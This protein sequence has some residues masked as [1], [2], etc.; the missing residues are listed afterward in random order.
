MRNLALD[1]KKVYNMAPC[2]FEYF[3]ALHDPF[4]LATNPCIPAAFSAQS[5][6]IR[7]TTRGTFRVGGNGSGGVA[8]WPFRGA[9][10]DIATAGTSFAPCLIATND[11]Y[12][13]P[14][15]NFTNNAVVTATPGLDY[16]P[17]TTSPYTNAEF[18]S[19]A[20]T[21]R[22]VAAG[23]RVQYIDKVLDMSGDYIAIRNPSCT[24]GFAADQD[25]VS[26]LL[27]NRTATYNR[28]TE[29]WCGVTYAPLKATDLDPI[30][31]PG[32]AST[33][34]NQV[35]ENAVGARF[36][37]GVFI[38]NAQPG[39]RFG[40]EF[41]G[42]YECAGPALPTTYSHTDP[43]SLGIVTEVTM[44][45]LP[46][47]DLSRAERTGMTAL[48]RSAANLGYDAVNVVGQGMITAAGNYISRAAGNAAAAG[49]GPALAVVMQGLRRGRP[50]QALMLDQNR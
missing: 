47:P 29:E 19:T 11:T 35:S 17:G 15:F 4:S 27:A 25:T 33:V 28:V 39:Q 45:E 34:L 30:P 16:Y 40:F 44:S 36:A 22:L 14:D 6:K 42:Y 21:V 37:G 31:A 50:R 1:A 8:F 3:R 7:A 23:L 26:Q 48:A 49:A 32:L 43:Q 38:Q 10:R 20:R 13:Q 24:T 2:A 18:T 12:N 46:D 9:F 41:I 5:Q